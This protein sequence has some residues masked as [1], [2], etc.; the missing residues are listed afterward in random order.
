LIDLMT[1]YLRH[2]E[3]HLASFKNTLKQLGS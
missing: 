1:D 2:M 3:A